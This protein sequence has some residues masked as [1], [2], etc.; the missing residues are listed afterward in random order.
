M[1]NMFIIGHVEF[2]AHKN[3]MEEL[4]GPCEWKYVGRQTDIKN[5]DITLTIAGEKIYFI[6][7]SM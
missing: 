6:Q 4:Y 2:F 1:V 5:P 7:T 3:K